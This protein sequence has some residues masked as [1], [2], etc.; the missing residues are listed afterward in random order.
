MDWIKNKAYYRFVCIY[1]SIVSAIITVSPALI[2]MLLPDNLVWIVALMIPFTVVQIFFVTTPVLNALE[3]YRNA[4]LK[5]GLIHENDIYALF[6]ENGT[7]KLH[8]G[9]IDTLPRYNVEIPETKVTMVPKEG[10]WIGDS[11]IWQKTG[12]PTK[13]LLPTCNTCGKEFGMKFFEDSTFKHC[14]GCG[15]RITLA[16]IP[17]GW[18][19]EFQAQEDLRKLLKD[20]AE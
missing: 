8:V 12:E 7:A 15:K 3:S 2:A 18:L 20:K 13:H 6:E 19:E 5:R 4:N 16:R 14:P 11:E 17:D 9:D 1:I 10:F